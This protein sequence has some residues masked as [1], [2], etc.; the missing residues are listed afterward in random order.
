MGIGSYAMVRAI[1][2][3]VCHSVMVL[4]GIQGFDL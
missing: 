3:L 1:Q 4:D 2:V